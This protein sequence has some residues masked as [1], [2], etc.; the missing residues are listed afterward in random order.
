MPMPMKPTPLKYCMSCGAQLRRKVL[1]NKGGELES[2]LHFSRRKFCSR[3]CMSDGFRGRERKNVLPHQGRWRARQKFKRVCCKQCGATKSL[4]THHING[5][6]LDNSLSNLECLC[7][8]CHMKHHRPARFCE[9]HQ[10]GRPHKG[11]GL[12]DMHL[13]RK[14]RGVPVNP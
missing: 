10:C 8:S 1:K 14:N 9:I 2:L 13:Q 4:D 6:P 11:H 5:N 3:E 12:C 7:R